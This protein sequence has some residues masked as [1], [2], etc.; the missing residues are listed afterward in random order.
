M[1]QI[2]KMSLQNSSATIGLDYLESN[3]KLTDI[4]WNIEVGY[5]GTINIWDTNVSETV[6]VYENTFG[7][8]SGS[9]K[10]PGFNKLVDMGTYYD[11]PLNIEY[12]MTLRKI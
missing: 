4:V 11:L 12:V 8:G 10:V 6:P 2:V 9:D 5:I 7:A 1:A 3:L